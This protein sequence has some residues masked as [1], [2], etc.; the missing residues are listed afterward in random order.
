M[1]NDMAKKA[2][3]ILNING[4]AKHL[5]IS[6]QT[7]HTLLRQGRIKPD[8]VD[9][10]GRRFWSVESAEQIAMEFRAGK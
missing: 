4:L 5:N 9:N 3:E 8:F 7:I 6:R 2:T 10:G 1:A